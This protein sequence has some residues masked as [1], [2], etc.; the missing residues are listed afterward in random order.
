M[1]RPLKC[2]GCG[3][4]YFTDDMIN[5]MCI[6]CYSRWI[7]R[8]RGDD[9]FYPPTYV[10]SRC[11]GRRY[12]KGDQF[13]DLCAECS[14]VQNKWNLTLRVCAHCKRRFRGRVRK[15][16]VYCNDIACSILRRREARMVI[17]RLKDSHTAQEWAALVELHDGT[18]V[19]CQESPATSK[20]HIVPVSRGG[21]DGIDNLVP[22]CLSCNSSKGNKLLS[23]W[24]PQKILIS[25]LPETSLAA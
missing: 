4:V 5:R 8:L 18:C 6:H 20:D 9:R 10:C 16:R 15:G 3:I 2:S 21:S 19:Y 22:A 23:E 11:A 12:V 1:N 13:H 24:L 17:A 7:T 25:N 14:T